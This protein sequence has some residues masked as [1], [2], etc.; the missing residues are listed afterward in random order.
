MPEGIYLI[1]YLGFIDILVQF[2]IAGLDKKNFK[3][4]T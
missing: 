1:N 4:G 3:Y 2:P